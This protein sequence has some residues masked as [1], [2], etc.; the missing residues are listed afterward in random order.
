MRAPQ[1]VR[2]V[3]FIAGRILSLRGRRVMID[4]DLA[5]LYGVNTK[6]L[7]QAVKRNIDRFPDDFMFRLTAAE[8][9]EVVTKCDHLS[10]LKYSPTAPFA[11][12]EYGAVMLASV[13][14]S[15]RA[16]EVSLLV[17]RAF[18]Q[19]RDALSMHKDLAERLGRLEKRV[20][21][22]DKALAQLIE[23]IRQLMAP[24]ATE[25]RQIGFTANI[26]PR[27]AR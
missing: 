18:V 9:R 10:R 14:N 12:S 15:P 4:A 5:G 2:N 23:A 6:A 11:F 19:L 3:Q 7:N 21:G 16:V 25:T 8:K 13:L 1:S 24:P 20:A 27:R 17:V 22:H 26:A